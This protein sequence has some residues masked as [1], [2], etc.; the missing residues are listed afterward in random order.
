MAVP[1]VLPS[2]SEPGPGPARA[3]ARRR[4]GVPGIVFFVVAASAPLTVAAGGLPTSFAV[5]GVT[6]IPL[7]YVVLAVLLAAFT[8]GYAA[9]SRSV[10]NAGA[11]YAYVTHGLGRVPGVGAAFVAL[12][13]YNTM[14][15]GL[16]GLFGFTTA[17]LLKTKAHLDVPWWAAALAGA[18]AVAVLGFRRIDLNARVLGVLLAVEFLT[19]LVFDA[20]QLAGAPSGVSFGP[21][22]VDAARDGAVG[23]AFCFAMAS[24]MGFEAAAIYS[25]ECRDPRRTVGRATYAAVALIGV[26]YAF[27]AW[28]MTVGTGAEDIARRAREDGPGLVFALAEQHVGAL[29]ADLAQVFLVTSLFAAL[30]SFHNAVARYFFSLGREGV[31]PGVLGRTHPRHRSPH[32][33]SAA[34]S[35]LAVLAVA[36]FAA[37]GEDPVLTL[38]NWFTNLGALGVILLLA[39]TSAAVVRHFARDPRGENAW[40]RLAAPVLSGLGLAAVFVAC[41]L[42]FDALLGADRDSALV[43]LLP[44]LLL[45]AAVAGLLHA[46]YLRAARPDAYAR[47]G[48]PPGA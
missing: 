29:F 42:N 19:V 15:I 8:G 38:F 14:Q 39:L 22:G 17:D 16:Y 4:I 40:N 24:F 35:A 46:A 32:A 2:G 20:G 1:D 3:T 25:E 48:R 12:V 28:A 10:S 47:I 37:A 5:T 26:F 36:A 21:L 9:M 7:L 30:L 11:F 41:L 34:Q 45:A 27:T 13:S 44:G 31:L 23:A 33:G 6:G 43:W 18:A